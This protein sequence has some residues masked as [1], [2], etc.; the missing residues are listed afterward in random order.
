MTIV[1]WTNPSPNGLKTNP[2]LLNTGMSEL[3]QNFFDDL[4]LERSHSPFIPMAN[5]LDEDEY[6]KCVG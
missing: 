6:G 4:Q 2:L 3:L 5:V 1:K